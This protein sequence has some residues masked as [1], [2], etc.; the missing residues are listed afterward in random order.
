VAANGVLLVASRS[1]WQAILSGRAPLFH[2][3][4]F[5]FISAPEMPM[6]GELL[7]KSAIA[8][9]RTMA[10]E[11]EI[12]GAQ[13]GGGLVLARDR[14]GLSC[15]VGHKLVNAKRGHLT[16]ALEAGFRRQRHRAVRSG[17][18]PVPSSLLAAWHYRFGT[19]GPPA[20]RETHWHEW[21]P[22]QGR[23]LWRREGGRWVCAWRNVQH[24]ITHNGDFEAFQLFGT[25][26]DFLC[27]GPWLE[28]V[29]N[30]PIPAVADS[31]RIAG[32]MDLL[33]CQGDWFASVRLAYQ[34]VLA[35][36]STAPPPPAWSGGP[37][38]LKPPSW[39]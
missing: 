34:L 21:S 17:C 30:S 32:L 7:P 13:A 27:L 6:A 19:S 2:C 22:A 26:V 3:G 4:N 8:R 31:A 9:F 5:G 28:R 36:F 10:M 20:V 39:R 18:R 12:R 25:P 38:C 15:F 14:R 24:R 35:E 16:K 11:T 1:D 23:R 37:R 33:I 29:L